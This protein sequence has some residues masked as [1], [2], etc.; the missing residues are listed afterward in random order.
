M[1]YLKHTLYRFL[2]SETVTTILLHFVLMVSLHTLL[3]LLANKLDFLESS[4]KISLPSSFLTDFL[5]RIELEET[6]HQKVIRFLLRLSF[7]PVLPN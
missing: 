2:K 4:I 7:K 1:G 3:I 6:F 5:E